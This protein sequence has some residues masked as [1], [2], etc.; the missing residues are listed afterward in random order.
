[1][2]IL[3]ILLLKFFIIYEFILLLFSFCIKSRKDF[4][5]KNGGSARHTANVSKSWKLCP[6]CLDSRYTPD[7]TV[8]IEYAII[9]ML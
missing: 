1:M 9:T 6:E 5:V 7:Y 4:F 2:K 8:I 3:T